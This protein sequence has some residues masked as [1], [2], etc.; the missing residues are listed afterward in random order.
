MTQPSPYAPDTMIVLEV[1]SPAFAHAEPRIMNSGLI[2]PEAANAMWATFRRGPFG[3][4]TVRFHLFR[5][6]FVIGEGLVFDHALELVP[7]SRTQHTDGEIEEHRQTLRAALASANL[8]EDPGTTL[9]CQKRGMENYGHWMVELLPLAFLAMEHLKQ[10][11]W[12]L[13]AP[14]TPGAMGAVIRESLDLLGI[15][16][17]QRRFSSGAPRRLDAVILADGLTDH[18]CMMSPLVM[19]CMDA[20]SADILPDL[21]PNIWVNRERDHRRFMNERE[22]VAV[23]AAAGWRVLHP[24]AM[25]LRRQIAAFKAGRHI[26]GV[27]GAGLTNIAFAAPGAR[28]TNFVPATMPDTFFWFLSTLRGHDYHEVRSPQGP[29]VYPADWDAALVM[30]L[31]Q[32]LAHLGAP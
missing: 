18:G 27:A 2:P 1:A 5:D 21:A 3:E 12:S 19:R 24:G 22:L 29:G 30:S 7:L 4:S 20:L 28:I 32:I 26:A 31:P 15:P 11:D 10:G 13:L 6:V 23:L 14:D 9:L 16:P 8:P 25:T 17:T